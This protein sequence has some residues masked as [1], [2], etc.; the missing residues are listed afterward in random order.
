MRINIL[1]WMYNWKYKEVW[2]YFQQNHPNMCIDGR[3]WVFLRLFEHSPVVEY[4]RTTHLY[5]LCMY[6]E[7]PENT[8]NFEKYVHLY[9][10]LEVQRTYYFV[11]T[12]TYLIRKRISILL[13]YVLY[14]HIRTQ[15]VQ[16]SNYDVRAIYPL[17][18]RSTQG[19]R[20][21]TYF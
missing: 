6:T 13:V 17:G 14:I 5:V 16:D 3:V 19:L 18:L 10:Q 9:V 11:R 12:Y 2:L 21:N 4:V 8:R 1:P 20:H 7:N 15:Y